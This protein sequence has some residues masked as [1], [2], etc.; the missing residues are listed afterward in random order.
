M[1]VI[2]SVPIYCHNYNNLL[3]IHF[4]AYLYIMVLYTKGKGN[5][6]RMHEENS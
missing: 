5:R 3:Y 6:R 1:N 4:L 2:I